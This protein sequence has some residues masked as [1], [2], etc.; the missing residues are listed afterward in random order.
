[1][2]VVLTYDID[3]GDGGRRLRKVAKCCERYGSRVQNSVFEIDVPYDEVLKL[4]K[5][6]M[7]L[8]DVHVDSI[9]LYKLG[10]KGSVRKSVLGRKND[11]ELLE[12]VAFFF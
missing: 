5:E 1:M 6:L 4:E 11:V 3:Q 2:F 9:R 8:I 7:N 10:K 12:D